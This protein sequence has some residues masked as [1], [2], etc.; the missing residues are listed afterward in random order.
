MKIATVIDHVLANCE[1]LQESEAIAKIMLL[2]G[3]SFERS[4][5]NYKF[6]LT[7]PEFKAAIQPET[8]GTI[9]RFFE[10]KPELQMLFENFDCVPGRTTFHKFTGWKKP[11]P[12]QQ[13]FKIDIPDWI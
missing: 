7:R 4:Y 3:Y 2:T 13:N 10:L 6:L 1:S 12:F 8:I 5:N 11:V 9:E